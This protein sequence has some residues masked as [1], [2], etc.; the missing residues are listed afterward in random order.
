MFFIIMNDATAKILDAIRKAVTNKNK[1]PIVT[2]GIKKNVNVSKHVSSEV[3]AQAIL[4]AIQNGVQTNKLV[5]PV[6]AVLATN[7]GSSIAK[8]VPPEVLAQAILKAIKNGVQTNKLVTPVATVLGTNKGSN[9]V[10][11]VPPEVLAQAILKAIKNGVEPEA[12]QKTVGNKSYTTVT[13]MQGEFLRIPEKQLF[14]TPTMNNVKKRMEIPSEVYIPYGPENTRN[15]MNGTRAQWKFLKSGP[16]GTGYHRIF[17]RNNNSSKSIPGYYYGNHFVTNAS[18]VMGKQKGYILG[19]K[20]L[21]ET[22]KGGVKSMRQGG[23]LLLS[24]F[25]SRPVLKSNSEN[26]A[27]ANAKAAANKAAANPENKAAANKA[28]ANKAAA[29]AKAAANKAA[30]N[31]ENKAAANAKA[32]AN[33]AAANANAAIEKALDEYDRFERLRKL[34]TLFKTKGYEK[35]K[36]RLIQE[37]RSVLRKLYGSSNARRN[38]ENAKRLVGNGKVSRNVNS[39]LNI[40]LKRLSRGRGYGGVNRGGYGGVTRGGYGGGNRG[41]IQPTIS[42]TGAPVTVNVKPTTTTG[43]VN[44]KPPGTINI[45]PPTSNGNRY[46]EKTPSQLIQNGGGTEKIERGIE[47]LRAANGNVNKARV[48][49][50]LPLNT[51]TNIYAMGGPVAAKKAVTRIRRHRRR[52]VASKK[53]R[54]AHKPKKQYIKLTPYQFKRLTDHI[55]KNNL[56][57]VLIKEIT[58]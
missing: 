32:A 43:S 41:G 7:K 8:N 47:A 28:A 56:R 55:K 39:N 45:T 48:E 44:V 14:T 11:K 37:I 4:K 25:R 22:F 52:T 21:L 35:Y 17:I 16:R 3:L 54:V 31:P 42:V 12:L 19:N 57:K 1:I 40:A 30:A 33:K 58:H 49:S 26:K 27:A 2:E 18:G 36:P 5:T 50:R 15:L 6:A 34:Y 10:N 53:K 51:F 20:P 13:G 23:S 38:F 9:I 46:I 29:N 24:G